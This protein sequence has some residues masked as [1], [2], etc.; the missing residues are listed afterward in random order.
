[1][2]DLH[3]SL[4]R[5]IEQKAVEPNS[6]LGDAISYMR[7]HWKPLTRF[8]EVPGAPLD[9][10]VCE[11]VLKRA[12]MHR[13]N[14]LFFKTRRGAEVGDLY[15]SL[16]HTCFLNAADPFDYLT[17]LEK[18]HTELDLNPERWMPWNYLGRSE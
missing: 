14:S 8:L 13:K 10:N 11:Q 6:A 15:M 5:M 9:N 16:I 18:R 2:D 12:I 17:T 4:K 7:K 3:A 1:M